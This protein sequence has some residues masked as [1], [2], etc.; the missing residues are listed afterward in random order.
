MEPGD[1]GLAQVYQETYVAL[2]LAQFDAIVRLSR[3]PGWGY[4]TTWAGTPKAL[5]KVV[6][7]KKP[8]PGQPHGKDVIAIAE[9]KEV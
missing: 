1:T 8:L 2:P 5:H 6:L 4:E 9:I 3:V 7:T